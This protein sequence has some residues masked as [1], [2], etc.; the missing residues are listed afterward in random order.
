MQVLAQALASPSFELLK[1]VDVSAE[2]RVGEKV[3]LIYRSKRPLLAD[4]GPLDYEIPVAK[5]RVH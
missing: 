4:I 1:T 3:L 5:L 2:P